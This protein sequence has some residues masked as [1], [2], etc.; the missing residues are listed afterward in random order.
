METLRLQLAH[1]RSAQRRD[2]PSQPDDEINACCFCGL[3]QVWA[4]ITPQGGQH[5]GPP[6]VPMRRI[7]LGGFGARAARR[8]RCGATHN[9]QIRRSSTT[10]GRAACRQANSRSCRCTR[11]CTQRRRL[12]RATSTNLDG[13]KVVFYYL[14]CAEHRRGAQRRGAPRRRVR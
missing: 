6:T 12:L 5:V 14:Q 3:A 7:C 9:T 11:V 13:A 1:S 2:A 10:V 8:R 4:R